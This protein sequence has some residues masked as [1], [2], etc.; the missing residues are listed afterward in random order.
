MKV[1]ESHEG[2]SGHTEI[3]AP[4][5]HMPRLIG[6]AQL[7]TRIEQELLAAHHSGVL[8]AGD[9]GS[10]KTRALQ[11]TAEIARQLGMRTLTVS[12]SHG[13]DPFKEL[14][15]ALRSEGLAVSSAAQPF[16]VELSREQR[17]APLVLCVDDAQLLDNAGAGVLVQ[18]SRE[19]ACRLAVTV[20]DQQQLPPDIFALW[21]GGSLCRL[22]VA[23]LTEEEMIGVCEASLVR[24]IEFA[25]AVRL[26]KVAQ[27]NLVVLR[28]LL[29]SAIEEG[30]M[31]FQEGMWR[32]LSQ[33]LASPRLTELVSPLLVGINDVEGIALETLSLAGTLPLAVAD[34]VVDA[35]ILENLEVRGLICI[36]G[37]PQEITVSIADEIVRSVV[38]ERL[39]LL[40]RRR[41]LRKLIRAWVEHDNGKNDGV[42]VTLWRLEVG[43]NVPEERLHATSR[44]AWWGGDWN[45]ACRLAENAWNMY[46]T[47]GAGLLLSQILAHQGKISSA[48]RIQQQ[49]EEVG[50]AS[51]SASA[52][53]ISYRR[54]LLHSIAVDAVP[55]NREKAQCSALSHGASEIDLAISLVQHGNCADALR[56]VQPMLQDGDPGRVAMAGSLALAASL[57]MGRPLDALAM[58]PRLTWAMKQLSDSG[59]LGYDV[60]NIPVLTAYARGIT[61]EQDS[62][63]AHLRTQVSE[64]ASTRNTAL[65]SRA[66][67]M[68][69]RLLFEQGHVVESHKLFV[70]SDGHEDLA[71]VQQLARAGALVASSHLSDPQAVSAAS[72]RLKAYLA[73]PYRRVEV[74]IALALSEHREGRGRKAVKLLHEAARRTVKDE[75]FGELADVVHALTRMG[76]ARSAA[77]LCGEWSESL[78][79]PLDSVRVAFAQGVAKGDAKKV[80]ECAEKFEQ[81][82]V[83]LF[84][85]EA[86]AAASI[87][88]RDAGELRLATS[89][90]WRCDNARGQYDGTPTFL[91]RALQEVE[92][93]SPR[94]REVA[95]LA[96]RGHSSQEIADNL[97]VSVR[98]IDNHLYRA[99]RKLGV[100]N[101]RELRQRLSIE[102]PAL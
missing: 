36:S 67:V 34:V 57:R 71:V 56:L 78:Q 12:L 20:T 64:A 17:R 44:Q 14:V 30:G 18:L 13:L 66:G 87:I 82:R 32:E 16:A 6:R 96:A 101:R 5:I 54:K 31:V 50:S 77:D 7:L 98:T 47:P 2:L 100:A 99:Y 76:Q 4:L 48:E 93:L 91:L 83:P 3:P 38:L 23:K 10:G 65:A 81:S 25:T 26:S 29:T 63:I 21:K 80:S 94:E 60:L 51:D 52:R 59:I 15:G 72:Q 62:A 1:S 53:R 45:T 84:A 69:A 92:H 24:P 22:P 37:P 70:S 85:A 9:T 79:A 33:N 68:L 86:W 95:F 90:V 41:L 43:D 19:G 58:E 75:A 27:G 28:E 35:E 46:K 42:Q 11:E 73:Y 89:T 39:S 74:D 102:L 49:I 97:V 61:G 55:S 40:R 8:M 88:H